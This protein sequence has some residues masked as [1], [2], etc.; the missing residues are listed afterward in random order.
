VRSQGRLRN[1]CLHDRRKR[2]RHNNG[3]KRDR[4]REIPQDSAEEFHSTGGFN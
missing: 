4:V 3:G 2:E 1:P